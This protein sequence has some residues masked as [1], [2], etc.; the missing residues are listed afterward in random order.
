MYCLCLHS[1]TG[2]QTSI[3]QNCLTTCCLLARSAY[4]LMTKMKA[5]WSSEMLVNFYLTTW[6]HTAEECSSYPQCVVE[7][8]LEI[9]LLSWWKIWYYTLK[10]L[11]SP[12]IVKVYKCCSFRLANNSKTKCTIIQLLEKCTEIANLRY[13][14]KYFDRPS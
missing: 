10:N 9:F 5:V 3:K 6:H 1:R 13:T 2:S 8:C 4:S 12:L 11:N 7:L 14:Y